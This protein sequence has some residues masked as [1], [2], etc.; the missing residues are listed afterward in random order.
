MGFVVNKVTLRQSFLLV[1]RLS[2]TN[3]IPPVLQTHL[4]TYRQRYLIFATDSIIK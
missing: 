4:I 2:P 1:L 3:I